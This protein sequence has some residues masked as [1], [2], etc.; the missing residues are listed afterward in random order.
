MSE[1]PSAMLA[2]LLVILMQ[3]IIIFARLKLLAFWRA[4]L[5]YSLNHGC[6]L[7]QLNGKNIQNVLKIAIVLYIANYRVA[8][9]SKADIVLHYCFM[10]NN[11]L[12]WV[13][14]NKINFISWFYLMLTILGWNDVGFHNPKVKTPNIDW[15]ARNGIQLTNHYSYPMCSP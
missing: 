10:V 8:V 5:P 3:H 12:A 2:T 14:E 1:E 7:A 9:G 15:L 6:T 11:H 4:Q 13:E